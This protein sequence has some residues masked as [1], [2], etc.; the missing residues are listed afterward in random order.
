MSTP[1]IED[2]LVHTTDTL[3][4]VMRCI[5]RSGRIGLALLVDDDTRLIAT[6]TN[7]DIRRGLLA[8]LT[9]DATTAALLPIKE[10]MPNPKAVT[11]PVRLRCR[12]AALPHAGARTAPPAAGGR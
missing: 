3:E 12:R 9:L 4:A 5:D 10:S 1:A 7:G 6:I 2:L 8:G 11:A